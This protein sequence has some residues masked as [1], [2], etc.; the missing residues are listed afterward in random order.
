[1]KGITSPCCLLIGQY[2]HHMTLCP[3]VE[4]MLWNL[5]IL[6]IGSDLISNTRANVCRLPEVQDGKMAKVLAI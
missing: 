2:L 3:P 5:S 1:M 6:G 4:K